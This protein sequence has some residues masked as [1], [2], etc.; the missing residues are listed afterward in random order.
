VE[1]GILPLRKAAA[2]AG[3][4]LLEIW[5]E[6]PNEYAA[7]FDA[8]RGAG[9]EALMIVPTPELYRDSEQLGELA[10]R[11]GLPTVGGFRGGAHKDLLIGY[12][13]NLRELSQQAVGYVERIFNGAQA[14]YRSKVLRAL[15][16][17]ST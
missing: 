11:S 12:G 6:S 4:E 8:M 15:T 10:A 9:V 3:L 17:L 7:A 16:S 14:S 1:A 2:E 5:V 13:P